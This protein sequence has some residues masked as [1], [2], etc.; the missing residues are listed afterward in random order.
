MQLLKL[1]KTIEA[2]GNGGS[3]EK[4]AVAE[5]AHQH[6]GIFGAD[7][8]RVLEANPNF[9]HN[10]LKRI[11]DLHR[12]HVTLRFKM[13]SKSKLR[14]E[15][16]IFFEREKKIFNLHPNTPIDQTSMG[17]LLCLVRDLLYEAT[18]IPFIEIRKLYKIGKT[19]TDA[20]M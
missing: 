14:R 15:D 19:L 13:Q 16:L 12:D 20:F 10:W 17:F 8:K 2:D 5:A 18:I 11:S 3:N 6:I 1:F 4:D 7:P 9:L